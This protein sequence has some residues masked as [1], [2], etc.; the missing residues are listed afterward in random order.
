M[1]EVILVYVGEFIR[2]CLGIRVVCGRL[3]T[4]VDV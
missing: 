3:R 2:F 1:S 4:C